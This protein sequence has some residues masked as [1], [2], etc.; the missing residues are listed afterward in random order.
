MTLAVRT[1]QFVWVEDLIDLVE[2]KASCELYWLLK[3]PDEK[4]VT[5]RAYDNPRF[6]EDMVREV[7][8]ALNADPRVD[9][10]TVES[11]NFDLKQALMGANRPVIVDKHPCH[12]S[13]D[14]CGYRHD[15]G[16]HIGII[17]AHVILKAAP[18]HIGAVEK[19][20][21]DEGEQGFLSEQ[22]ADY[23]RQSRHCGFSLF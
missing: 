21:G 6:V 12:R 4:F 17:R 14:L 15:M 11:E 8:S 7:A 22:S 2:K 10:Y 19:Q 13:G 18:I 23:L 5:E 16:A 1:N 9:A 3:R 20:D